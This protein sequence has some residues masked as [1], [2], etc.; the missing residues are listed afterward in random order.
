MNIGER[1]KLFRK[2]AN[3]TQKEL[4]EKLNVTGTTITRYEK[5]LRTPDILTLKKIAEVFNISLNRI[6]TF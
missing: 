2:R 1:I 3:L 4:G 6:K 5:N